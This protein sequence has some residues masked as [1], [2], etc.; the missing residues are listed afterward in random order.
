MTQ[1]M[2]DVVR[3]NDNERPAVFALRIDTSGWGVNLGALF[4]KV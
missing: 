4:D 2:P 1:L 3:F